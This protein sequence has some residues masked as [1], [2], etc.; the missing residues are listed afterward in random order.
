[1][2]EVVSEAENRRKVKRLTSDTDVARQAKL[3]L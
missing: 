3:N 2:V 1:M